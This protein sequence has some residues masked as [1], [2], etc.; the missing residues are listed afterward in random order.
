MRTI[1]FRG[2]DLETGKFVYGDLETRPKED[3]MVI[4]QYNEDGSYKSQ[5]KVEQ[6]TVGQFTGWNPRKCGEL[7]DGD[8]IGFDDWAFNERQRKKMKHHV[9]LIKWSDEYGK[10]QIWCSDG[11]YEANDVADPQ[12]LGNVHDNPDLLEKYNID[13]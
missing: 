4:H 3:I 8:I 6:N 5:V 1:K 12:L 2:R 13:F 7:Y 10:Y 9:G 11:V